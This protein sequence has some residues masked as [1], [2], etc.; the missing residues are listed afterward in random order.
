M[1]RYGTELMGNMLGMEELSDREPGV[2]IIISG[3]EICMSHI[4]NTPFC[5]RSHKLQALLCPIMPTRASP[6]LLSYSTPKNLYCT[7]CVC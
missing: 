2:F 3:F 6:V 5:P 1:N 4:C 7:L